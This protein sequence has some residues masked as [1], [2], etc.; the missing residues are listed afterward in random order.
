[1][2]AEIIWVTTEPPNLSEIQPPSGRISAPTNG[3][4][5]AQVNALGALGLATRISS[6][7]APTAIILPKITVIDSGS[8]A[9]KPIKEPKVRMYRTVI[10]QVCL[11]EK[12]RN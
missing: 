3:P 8:A 6:P 10:D 1:M 11:L 4:I 2:M 9:E 5:Q 12:I 7:S